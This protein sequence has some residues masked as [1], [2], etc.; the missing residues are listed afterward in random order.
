MTVN[1]TNSTERPRLGEVLMQRKL[2]SAD[3]LDKALKIQKEK[4]ELHGQILIS[5]K[6]VEERDIVVALILQC[7]IPYI[8]IT[9]FA[10][11][12]KVLK[13]VPEATAQKF[14]LIPIDR[15]DGILSVVMVDPFDQK[16]RKEL[17]HTT[18]C[19]I[20]PFIATLSEI[21]AAIAKYYQKGNK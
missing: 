14:H 3:Q 20:V 6:F 4:D 9:K 5:L 1:D 7:G 19:K 15:I 16:T 21:D 2:L 18:K 13:L 11:D 17:E 10:I 8:S 12:P